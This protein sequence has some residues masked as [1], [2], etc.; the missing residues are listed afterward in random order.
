[1]QMN[2]D[3][4]VLC[5][6]SPKNADFFLKYFILSYKSLVNF[7]ENSQDKQKGRATP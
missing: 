7:V 4:L 6:L 1:M 5:T 2:T 3:T